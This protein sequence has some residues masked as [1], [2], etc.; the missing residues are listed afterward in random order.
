MRPVAI[1]DTGRTRVLVYRAAARLAAGRRMFD[2]ES[3][4][5]H[6]LAAQRLSRSASE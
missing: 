6:D 2:S 5:R 3:S 4:G 1:G